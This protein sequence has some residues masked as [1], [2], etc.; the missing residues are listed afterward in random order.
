MSKNTAKETVQAFALKQALRYV[1][2]NPEENLPRLAELA[3]KLLPEGMYPA[4]RRA[5]L[6][7][8]ESRGNW[9]QLMLRFFELDP[10]V[11]KTF[12]ENF[13]FG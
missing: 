12:F 10:G 8:V 9:Y 7:A 4:Q 3:D 13:I 11:R 1:E 5:I 2:G 6:D